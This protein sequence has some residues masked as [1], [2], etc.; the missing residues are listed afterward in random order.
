MSE[1]KGELLNERRLTLLK[2]QNIQL[3]RQIILLSTYLLFD[4]RGYEGSNIRG[5]EGSNIRGYEGSY[6]RGKVGMNIRSCEDINS[7]KTVQISGLRRCK[8][9]GLRY[10]DSIYINIMI[11]EVLSLILLCSC[12]ATKLLI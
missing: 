4:I 3:E 10:Y 6:I 12:D 11:S 9:P 5:Y 7:R 1:E 8:Y 2:S